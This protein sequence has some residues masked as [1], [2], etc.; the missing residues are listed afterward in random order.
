[1]VIFGGLELVAAGYVLHEL[2]KDEDKARDARDDRH[3]RRRHHSSSRPPRRDSDSRP[4]PPRPSTQQL[5]AP[6]VMGPPRPNSAPPQQFQQRPPNMQ[7]MIGP[8]PFPPQHQQQQPYPVQGPP[9]AQTWPFQAQRP[10]MSH[11]QQAPNAG[12][13][14]RPQD[15][16]PNPHQAPPF[17]QRPPQISY[18]QPPQPGPGFAPGQIARP[19]TMHYDTKTG[20]WQS[21][22]LPRD[23]QR[24]ESAP[25]E[26]RS[27]GASFAA[28]QPSRL[29]EQHR[30]L[31]SG[32]DLSDS[33]SDSSDDELA[34]GSLPG[35]RRR[36]RA[37]DREPYLAKTA[38]H[39]RGR[40]APDRPAELPT[41]GD[42]YARR[43]EER[44][45]SHSSSQGPGPN[46]TSGN[47]PA[48]G[49]FE[50]PHQMRHELP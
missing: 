50:L 20:K 4:R 21:N 18:Q 38:S 2:G 48:R 30:A 25:L 33:N 37:S 15:F 14:F 36:R 42:W 45:D 11:P 27:R 40:P 9:N 39:E 13:M 1:M 19:P 22:M 17:Q 29:R 3:R 43:R 24:S 7:G 10:P 31:S 41:E 8:G 5:L 46:T 35:R 16:P 12:P 6:P 26:G 28:P 49:P 34:Y 32:S 23:I 47:H 44:I